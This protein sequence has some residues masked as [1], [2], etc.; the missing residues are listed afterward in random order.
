MKLNPSGGGIQSPTEGLTRLGMPTLRNGI[1]DIGA[2]E[3]YPGPLTKWTL[4]GPAAQLP[5]RLVSETGPTLLLHTILSQA[6][7]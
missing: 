7:I 2:R 1:K 6:Q 3:G 5:C 4:P